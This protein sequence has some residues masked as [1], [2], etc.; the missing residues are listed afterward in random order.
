MPAELPTAD[1][2]A[3]PAPRP[4]R[5]IACAALALLFLNAALS[6]STWWP[7]PGIV[8]DHRIAPEFVWLWLV[9]LGWVAWR[10][11]LGARALTVFTLGYLAL[12]IGRYADV[13]VPALFGRSINLY[14]DGIQIPRFLWVSA[15]DLP[16]WVSAGVVLAVALGLW[17]LFRALKLA[18][19]VTAREAVPYA[20]A[21]RWVW[22]ASAALALLMLANYAGVRATWPVVSKPVIP[23]YWRQA[24]LLSAA[25][26]PQRLAEVLP[27]RTAL[28]D[29][30]SAQP[31]GRRLATLGGRD[32]YV[33]ML[34]S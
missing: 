21:R 28:D 11:A 1:G 18:M 5:R 27:A 9:L 13:T 19:R 17:L 25:F 3:L 29:A 2:A 8:L 22:G 31:A 12:V 7:T 23:V 15:Q 14:W 6:F 4:W 32:V 16:W 20:L 26:S 33:I 30:L 24:Q 10:G 34:E